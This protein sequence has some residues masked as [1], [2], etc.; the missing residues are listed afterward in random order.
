MDEKFILTPG[1]A[2]LG[3]PG[4]KVVVTE[5]AWTAL[6]LRLF[7]GYEIQRVSLVPEMG[8]FGRMKYR[9]KRVLVNAP[10]SVD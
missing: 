9:K 7:R 5:S 8:R 2:E 1:S 4:G 10:P 6:W 3:E